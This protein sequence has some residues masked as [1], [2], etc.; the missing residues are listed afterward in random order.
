MN[1]KVASNQQE[2]EQNNKK[3][4]IGC[5]SAFYGDS[6]LAARQLVEKGDID[7]L[8]FDYLAEA[9][10]ALLARAKAKDERFGYAVDF[11]TVAMK[12]VLAD[13]AQ[14]G[15]KVIANAGGVN[16]PACIR[17]LQQLCEEQDLKL[18][19]AGVYGDD[20]S[21]KATELA[22]QGLPEMETGQ[23]L[24]EK[25]ASIN[26]YLG[27]EPISD[28]LQA[29]AD[30]VVTGRV[31]DSAVVIAPLM[32]EFNWSWDDYDK[33][34]Q[35][36]LAGHV[37]ECGA[38]C[39]GGNFTDWYLVPDFSD[40]SY[41]I[42][43][44]SADGAVD[45]VIPPA[46]GGLVT[47]GTVG[48]QLLYEIGDPAN[49]LLPDVSCDFTEVSITETG[50]D[51]VQLRGAKGRA[52]GASYKICATYVDGY[53]LLN[54]AFM[55]GPRSAEKAR[56]S[57]NAWVERTRRVF[58][59]RGWGDYRDVSIQVVGAEDTYGPHGRQADTREVMAKYG[60]HHDNPQALNFASNEMAYLGTSGTPGISGFNL[61]RVRPT[62][63]M[64]IHSAL[65]DKSLVPV[66]VQLGDKLLHEKCY[67]RSTVSEPS[68]GKAYAQTDLIPF[69]VI[70][71]SVVPA[72]DW[73]DVPL[74]QL[75]FTRSGDKGDNANVGVI[76][77]EPVFVPYLYNQLT[78]EAVAE[79]LAHIVK[80]EVTRFDVPGLHG[81]NFL[82]T[83]ALGGGGSASIVIDPQGKTLGQM[84]LSMPIKV[85]KNLLE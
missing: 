57:F 70:E 12:D 40:I 30:V 7:Y 73:V 27:A 81:F 54:S 67:E 34:A 43:E 66:C 58:E 78:A 55:A 52:P 77:R 18:N 8:V 36:A 48:E 10:M 32:A 59:Q 56:T 69:N 15:I 2:K 24:P 39:T 83:K 23:A 4:R 45:I 60:L 74:E 49:Y 82:M 65:V 19:I 79:Y 71:P 50:K 33:L 53:R 44:V 13:C 47:V 62:P 85:P 76:A 16:V 26:A 75:A 1:N 14:K 5:A 68:A 6:Q 42:A 84:L 25:L 63:L 41:P 46:T 37:I 61:G 3:I 38:Q 21:A 31:V 64:R 17:A 9:T 29:G 22:E 80:G 51:R 72:D 35:A 28:A 11:V 20:L